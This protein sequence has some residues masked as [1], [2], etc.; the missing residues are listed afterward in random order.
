MLRENQLDCKRGSE[1]QNTSIKA[2]ISSL[3]LSLK[4][5]VL[6]IKSQ[7]TKEI[8]CSGLRSSPTSDIY[9]L[10]QVFHS[11]NVAPSCSVTH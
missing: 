3:L 5:C 1:A 6:F 4:G 2:N 10:T 11:I 9:L 8:N 7:V